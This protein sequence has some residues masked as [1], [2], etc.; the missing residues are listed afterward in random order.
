MTD[1]AQGYTIGCCCC[2]SGWKLTFSRSLLWTLQRRWGG[3]FRARFPTS[4]RVT[5]AFRRPSVIS[6]GVWLF[7]L[8]KIIVLKP[9]P[10][11][12]SCRGAG[13]GRRSL[14]DYISV[15]L[16]QRP[17]CCWHADAALPSPHWRCQ[18]FCWGQTAKL[19]SC[20]AGMRT[21]ATLIVFQA[22]SFKWHSTSCNPA[23]TTS[24]QRPRRC[25]NRKCYVR[26]R[27]TLIQLSYGVTKLNRKQWGSEHLS[28]ST[29]SCLGGQLESTVGMADPATT[30]KN[31][32]TE[33]FLAAR[34][35]EKAA[36]HL[37]DKLQQQQQQQQLLCEK[38]KKKK[39]KLAEEI[40]HNDE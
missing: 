24:Q 2:P 4:H 11:L 40:D 25:E 14:T 26:V 38:K 22:H 16:F 9:E 8:T 1:R 15:S 29:P 3:W 5:T 18:T 13:G 28:W 21:P 34:K 39:K 33:S 20:P 17:S 12:L 7:A 27:S 30:N 10:D 23:L 6:V 19:W 37:S 35:L 31:N 32:F 36:S